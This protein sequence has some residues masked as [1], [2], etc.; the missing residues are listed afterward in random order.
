LPAS[1]YGVYL[2]KEN[3]MAP[4]MLGVVW[5]ALR[6]VREFSVKAAVVCGILLGL[7]ALTGNAALSLAGSVALAL[8]LTPASVWQKVSLASLIGCVAIAVASP[9]MIRN[10]LVI[11]APVLNTNGGF[12]LYIG[13]NPAA[14]GWFVSISDTP[15]GPTW[16]ELRN[17]GEVEAS[18]TLKTEALSWI[19]AHPG[20]FLALAIKKIVYFWSPPFH[21]GRGRASS[22][23]SAV[24]V[25]W[26]IQFV[27]LVVG[28][29]AGL[30]FARLRNRRTTVLW[31]SILC[32]TGVHALFYVIFRYRE[33]I[34]PFV[35]LI[36]ALAVEALLMKGWLKHPAAA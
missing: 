32:Y 8:V 18:E 23:E 34:M 19:T 28:A 24:R 3:L 25:L 27:T 16:G 30:A 12:N 33:P 13:N 22:A 5:C 35:G 26:A 4:L 10:A 36:A 31:L 9:W 21:E 7:L 29:V 20:E 11:G 15:R 2:A 1:V 14:T 6:L 17:A